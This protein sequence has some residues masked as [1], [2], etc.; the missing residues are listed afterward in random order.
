MYF[1]EVRNLSALLQQLAVNYVSRGYFFYVQGMI[2]SH[3]DA[4]N[5]DEKIISQYGIDVSKWTNWRKRREG[6]ASV[7]YLRYGRTFFILATP[8]KHRFYTQEFPCIRDVR[9]L[10]IRVGGYSIMLCESEFRRCVSIRLE[11]KNFEILKEYFQN[12]ALLETAERLEGEINGLNFEFYA[13]VCR[14]VA[15]LIRLLNRIRA[16]A[17]LELIDPLRIFRSRRSQKIFKIPE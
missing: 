3:K 5:T 11:Q 6:E 13:P 17:G 2:P 9:R 8:G 12:L 1:C 10:P 14:Q 15:Q 16:Q 4:K 7:Q